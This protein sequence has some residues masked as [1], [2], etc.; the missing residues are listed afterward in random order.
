[1]AEQGEQSWENWFKIQTHN[2]ESSNQQ[3]LALTDKHH[4][5]EALILSLITEQNKTKFWLYSH[6]TD[7]SNET[8]SIQL[9]T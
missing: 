6:D 1:M 5:Q 8:K 9:K 4:V 3:S 2:K 7:V